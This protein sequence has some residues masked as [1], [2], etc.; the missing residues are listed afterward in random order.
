MCL[1]GYED[2]VLV[3]DFLR[4]VVIFVVLD[5]AKGGLVLVLEINDW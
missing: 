4:L 5:G 3:R 2:V 1:S